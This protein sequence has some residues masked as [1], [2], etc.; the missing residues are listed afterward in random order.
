MF[1]ILADTGAAGNAVVTPDLSGNPCLAYELKILLAD[2]ADRRNRNCGTNNK[3]ETKGHVRN[4]YRTFAYLV[5]R[6]T[7]DQ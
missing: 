1:S 5:A 6:R 3:E 4:N 7:G 2:A